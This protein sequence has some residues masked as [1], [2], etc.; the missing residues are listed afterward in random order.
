[1]RAY[2]GSMTDYHICRYQNRLEH[3]PLF[4]RGGIVYVFLSAFF[5]GI[6]AILATLAIERLGGKYGGILAS[7]PTTIIPASVGF[8][9]TADGLEDFRDSLYIVPVGMLINAL[10]LLLW[11]VV[12]PK[13]P[14]ISLNGQLALMSVIGLSGWAICAALCIGALQL[15]VISPLMEG[16]LSFGV[17]IALGLWATSNAPPTPKGSRKVSLLM[18][19]SRGALAATAVGFAVFLSSLGI[20]ILAGMASVFP[21]IFLTTMVSVWLAQGHSVQ[22]GAVGPMM[23]GS[24][25]VSGYAL[26]CAWFFPLLG[27]SLGALAAWVLSVVTCSGL[28]LW[29]MRQK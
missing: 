24:S 9:L 3:R 1:M 5:S 12:P 27:P 6:V 20:A 25:S 10:F 22:A 7:I 15:G 4:K 28:A 19:L 23:L 26:L 21:A 2:L 17:A 18:L 16:G 29:W 14:Q 8:W 13:L 11:R